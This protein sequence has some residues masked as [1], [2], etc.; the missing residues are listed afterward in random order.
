MEES[1]EKPTLILDRDPEGLGEIVESS[2]I[3]E[4]SHVREVSDA[5]E[6]LKAYICQTRLFYS[7]FANWL[8][9]E[10]GLVTTWY[11]RQIFEKKNYRELP[12]W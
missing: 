12:G 6:S 5:Q 10:S 2:N 9:I 8:I 7:L 3:L 4:A 1:G 11:F